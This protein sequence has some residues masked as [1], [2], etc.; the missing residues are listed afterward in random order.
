ML[1]ASI[2]PSVILLFQILVLGQSGV[3]KLLNYKGN[4]DYFK[5]QFQ[6]SPLSFIVGL[7]F[8]IVLLLETGS[9]LVSVLGLF[10]LYTASFS[11]SYMKFAFGLSALTFVCLIFGQ[12]MAKDYA[13]ASGV[14]AYLIV[15]LIGLLAVGGM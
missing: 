12:R 8:P 14:V 2:L 11:T 6:N 5:S 3:D 10:S 9:A 13:G 15:S 1:L 7:L 4:L